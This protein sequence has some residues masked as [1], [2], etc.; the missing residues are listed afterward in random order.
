MVLKVRKTV[1]YVKEIYTDII[2]PGATDPY[3]QYIP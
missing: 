2:S 3:F 1:L